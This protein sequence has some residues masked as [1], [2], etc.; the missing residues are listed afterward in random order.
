MLSRDYIIN[1][2]SNWIKDYLIK[3]Y[4]FILE[5]WLYGSYA[6]NDNNYFSDID[7]L[8][9]LNDDNFNK[10]NILKL[11]S[12]TLGYNYP[13]LD[14]HCIQYDEFYTDQNDCY[15]KNIKNEGKILWKKTITNLQKMII[16][17]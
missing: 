10:N 17:E 8:L 7:I 1:Y 16:M 13:D 12:E 4:N 14:I 11:K 5:V 2:L 15:V 9:V 3:K 6:R